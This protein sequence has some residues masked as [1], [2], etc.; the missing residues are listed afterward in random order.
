MINN[1]ILAAIILLF[2]CG[3][4]S[5]FTSVPYVPQVQQKTTRLAALF[6][7]PQSNNNE[8]QTATKKIRTS[9]SSERRQSSN[10]SLPKWFRNFLVGSKLSTILN[11]LPHHNTTSSANNEDDDTTKDIVTEGTQSQQHLPGSRLLRLLLSSPLVEFKLSLLVLISSVFVAVGTVKS[12][13]LVVHNAIDFGETVITTLFLLEYLLRWY[14][15]D[16][17]ISHLFKPLVVVDFLSILPLAIKIGFYSLPFGSKILEDNLLV[18]L[19]LLRLLRFQRFLVDVETFKRFQSATGIQ[20]FD[21]VR[22]YHLQLARVIISIF[23][24]QT[25]SS[26]LIYAAERVVNP[27]LRDFPSAMYFVLTTVTTVGFGDITPVTAVGRMIVSATILMGAV[28][29]PLQITQF[30]E[31]LLDFRRDLE[32]KDQSKKRGSKP[33]DKNIYLP[34]VDDIAITNTS[35]NKIC[36]ACHAKPHHS[37]ATFCWNCASPLT[38]VAP[39]ANL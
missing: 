22:R 27:A 16:L 4:A 19:R 30:V 10:A 6:G 37:M 8:S 35:V 2:G 38:E 36:Q 34:Q 7:D 21:S 3:G 39:E 14:C 15:N 9:M 12:I 29:I 13:P 31:A 17:R 1:A 5:A 20:F 24:V 26:G 33:L 18:N 32:A 25:V 11:S 28:I 23:T